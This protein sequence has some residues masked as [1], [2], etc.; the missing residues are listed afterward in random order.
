MVLPTVSVSHVAGF[1]SPAT[2]ATP[3]VGNAIS[4]VREVGLSGSPPVV[5]VT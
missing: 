2:G 5:A 3:G 4:M 1:Q